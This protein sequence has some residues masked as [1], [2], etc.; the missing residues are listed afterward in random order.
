MR[1]KLGIDKTLLLKSPRREVESMP[2]KQTKS[3][4]WNIN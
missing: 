3:P 2:S 4:N 1:M